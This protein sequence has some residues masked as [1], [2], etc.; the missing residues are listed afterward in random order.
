M[1]TAAWPLHAVV[2]ASNKGRHRRAA[3]SI[4]PAAGLVVL[5][6]RSS[7]ALQ[8]VEQRRLRCNGASVCACV[9]YRACWARAVPCFVFR[10]RLNTENEFHVMQLAM[11]V[12][13][14]C[15][16]VWLRIK[17]MIN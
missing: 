7:G 3:L 8:E 1:L 14:Q 11:H 12:D 16:D 10:P 13:L 17:H 15:W 4:V 6:M 5:Q 9:L 2:C